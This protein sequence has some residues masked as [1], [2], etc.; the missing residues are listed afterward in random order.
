MPDTETPGEFELI[1]RY[2]APLSANEP[3][4]YSLTDDAAVIP[5]RAGH[6]VVI[7]MD[8]LV[9]GVHFLADTEPE[10]IAA[11]VVRVNMSDLAAMGARPAFYTLSLALPK[12]PRGGSGQ[13]TD[14]LWL[15]RFSEAL[16]IEQRIYDISIIGGDTVSTP[17][18]LTLT[19]T[20]FGYVEAGQA[21]RRSTANQGDL[22]VVSG[23]IGDAAFGLSALK[24][25]L[26]ALSK[27][28][29]EIV[30]ERHNRPLPQ[31]EL[32]L[33]LR[34]FAGAAIDVSDG[35]IQDLG[36]ICTES[37][38]TAVV[39]LEKV[40]TSPAV[41]EAMERTHREKKDILSGGDDYQLLFT[42]ASWRQAELQE[43]SKEIG[44]ELTVIGK[45]GQKLPPTG[46]DNLVSASAGVVVVDGDGS[47]IDSAF[48]GFRH[49]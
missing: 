44:V 16:G 19:I 23:T 48:A 15:E 31:I 28:S 22:V 24:G 8:T 43:I 42:I 35:L 13:K 6:D 38:V 41:R 5:S 34:N 20:A 45:I 36:H 46:V 7:T 26:A 47:P 10:H 4:A 40:P 37:G 11:K 29:R 9:S 18:P 39:E 27:S 12:N 21:I 3:G 14:G 32:G 2:L 25:E 1:K 17:G 30:V 49:F 33:R